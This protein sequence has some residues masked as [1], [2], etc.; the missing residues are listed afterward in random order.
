MKVLLINTSENTGG[1]AIA[2][3]RLMSALKNN[4][5]NVKLLV[6][7][8]IS[9]NPDIIGVEQN[10]IQRYLGLFKFVWER[11]II[12]INNH[13]SKK[14]LFSVSIANTGFNL[15][16]RKEVREAD[17]IHLHCINQGFLSLSDIKKLTTLGKPII[18]TLHD[19]WPITAICHHP[20]TCNKYTSLCQNCPQLQKPAP[21]DLSYR[22][23]KKKNFFAQ[24]YITFVSVSQWLCDKARQSNISKTS[25]NL[26]I[27]NTIDTQIF[28]QQDRNKIRAKLS[29]SKD[30]FVI[31]FGAAKLNDPIKGFDLLCHAISLFPIE[32]IKKLHLLMF[33]GIKNDENFLNTIPCKYTYMGK[34]SDISMIASLYSAADVTVV[35]SHYETFG[36]TLIESMACGTTVV[37]FDQGGQTDIIDHLDNGYLA[38]YP[39]VEDLSKGILWAY[40]QKDNPSLQDKCI[41]KVKKNYTEDIIATH[42]NHLYQKLLSTKQKQ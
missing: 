42:Y 25:L 29:I 4:G 28:Y 24:S 38:K 7:K 19:L 36:Q 37:S 39:S 40:E 5:V 31:L 11:F 32:Q 20:G 13:F 34:L 17:I 10:T 26:V 35:S 41:E 21:H 6:K 14:N 18:W 2:C 30:N 16:L 33:G 8:K 12:F 27:P 23:W 9:N 22:I 15:V 1:A 3:S